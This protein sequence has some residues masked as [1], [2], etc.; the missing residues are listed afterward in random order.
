MGFKGK[1]VSI[2]SRGGPQGVSE[3]GISHDLD[4]HEMDC[5]RATSLVGKLEDIVVSDTD[6]ERCL[7]LGKDLVPE[8]KT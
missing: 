5:D 1:K 3:K 4:P 2:I 6:N 7:K 8:V